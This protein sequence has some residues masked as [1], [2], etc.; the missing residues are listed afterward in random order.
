M[1]IFQDVNLLQLE[2]TTVISWMQCSDTTIVFL[3]KRFHFSTW[4]SKSEWLPYVKHTFLSVLN[5]ICYKKA[6]QNSTTEYIF[7]K[8]STWGRIWDPW[9]LYKTPWWWWLTGDSSLWK[10]Q[11]QYPSYLVLWLFLSGVNPTCEFKVEKSITK[12]K[13]KFPSVK[14]DLEG[15]FCKGCP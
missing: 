1:D 4:I 8:P 14:S 6:I 11:T 5:F 9:V 13:Y 7:Y 2:T 12:P 3:T 10:A 15:V